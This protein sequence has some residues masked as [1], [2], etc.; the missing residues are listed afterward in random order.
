MSLEEKM[1]ELWHLPDEDLA[2]LLKQFEM[3]ED[4]EIC[5]AIKTVLDERKPDDNSN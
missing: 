3:D 2:V 4:Y 5:L 1:D